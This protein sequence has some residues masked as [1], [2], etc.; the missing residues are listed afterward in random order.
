[1]KKLILGLKD[2]RQ[3][4]AFVVLGLLLIILPNEMG[5]AAPYV[6]GVS[7]VVYGCMN[8][9]LSLKYPESSLSLGDGV[10][11]I[12][13]GGVFLFLK[14]NAIA[15]IGVIWAMISLYEAA[16]KIDEYRRGKKLHVISVLSVIVSVGLAVLLMAD[17][18]EHFYTHVRIL[19]IE[20]IAYAILKGKNDWQNRKKRTG[21]D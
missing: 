14:G 20:I 5:T 3:V 21:G 17:P 18:F 9:V 11:C 13:A 2:N 4:Y 16:R 10:I 8:I 19:G 1:M 7:Q 12:V 15:I 6:L